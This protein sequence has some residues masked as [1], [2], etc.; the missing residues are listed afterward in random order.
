MAW[1]DTKKAKVVKMYQEANPTAETSVEIVKSIAEDVEETVNGVRMILSKAGVYI[2]KASA[3]T[4]GEGKPATE[5]TTRVS[6]A[7]SISEL[8]EVIS[9][10]GFTPNDEVLDKLTGKQAV[11][12]T[13]VIKPLI[14]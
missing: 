12:L 10:A 5:K 9:S 1:D 3:S 13:S 14:K 6:K 8:K 11:Y 7:D 4:G 2:S